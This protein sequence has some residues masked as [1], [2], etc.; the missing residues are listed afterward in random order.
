M[1]E[2]GIEGKFIETESSFL[3]NMKSYH[4]IVRLGVFVLLSIILDVAS[5]Q[6]PRA[7]VQ[8]IV[9][10]RHFVSE[11]G[12]LTL[13]DECE[14][15]PWRVPSIYSRWHV[16]NVSPEMQRVLDNAA[17][18]FG[19]SVVVQLDTVSTEMQNLP[20][21][22]E[23]QRK[24]AL[25]LDLSAWF[26]SVESYGNMLISQR[27]LDLA[28]V[29]VARLAANIEFPID[30][31][32]ALSAK[33]KPAWLDAEVRRRIL[34]LDA[35]ASIFNSA[36]L[37]QMELVFASGKYLLEEKRNPD[38][39]S[40]RQ[41]GRFAGFIFIETN[42]IKGALSFFEQVDLSSVD[43]PV[44]VN[45]W[46]E[47]WHVGFIVGLELQSVDK[48][49]ALVEFR[50]KIGSFPEEFKPSEAQ[51]KDRERSRKESERAGVEIVGVEDVFES[52]RAAAFSVSWKNYL[53][54]QHQGAKRA[55]LRY[56]NLDVIA[57]RAIKE[58]EKKE[59]LDRDA[60]VRR[61]RTA[62]SRTQ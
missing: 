24:T 52:S 51:M 3:G 8:A 32:E 13:L 41:A 23:L 2:K 60:S 31:V 33:L 42:E 5:A 47:S 9:E 15:R 58:V 17:R 10:M 25:L 27:C 54:N 19:K 57:Y 59:F 26:S 61:E 50:R 22:G 12:I 14:K 20:A 45:L 18:E 30:K 48:A 43:E 46:D 28:A 55:D 36:E 11:R 40:M 38:L 62:K 21:N 29:G 16:E 49:L 37:E 39:L 1:E 7:D 6:D 4:K 34:N 44:L 35:G 56:Y 53:D